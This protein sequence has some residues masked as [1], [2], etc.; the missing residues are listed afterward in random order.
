MNRLQLVI[1]QAD[2]QADDR[3][4]PV[5]VEIRQ[6]LLAG[7]T[8]RDRTK[9]EEHVREL[10]ALG[11]A[12]P[13]RI[14]SIFVVPPALVTTETRVQASGA[15]TS[16]EAEF[17]LLP[18]QDG[19]LVGVGSDHTDR[20]HEAVNVDESKAMCPKPIARQVWRYDE[21]SA[22]WDRLE[23]RSWV[24]DTGGRR[25]YQEGRLEALLSVGAL[26]VELAAA[27]YVDLAGLAVF[28]GTLPTH[29]GLVYGHRFEVELHDPV[30]G[31]R[32]G[33]TYDVAAAT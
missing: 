14:P 2:G 31:R 33:C 24:T 29:G 20:A 23:L 22:H 11:V 25:L 4:R 19:L 9:V 7:Y 28:G 32:L 27:G 8:G 6:V 18:S 10:A 21:V 1:H 26:L 15:Q 17:V 16:G 13:S 5:E 3:A 30:L 12:A